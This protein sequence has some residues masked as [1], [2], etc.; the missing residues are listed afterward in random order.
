LAVGRLDRLNCVEIPILVQS[1]FPSTAKSRFRLAV[2]GKIA[3]YHLTCLI[4]L[5]LAVE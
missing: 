3:G 1:N 5:L 4:D 2:A